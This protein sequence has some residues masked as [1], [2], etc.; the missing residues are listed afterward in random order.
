MRRAARAAVIPALF[1]LAPSVAGAEIGDY[2]GKPVSGVRLQAEGRTISDG[3]LLEL[4]ET[5]AGRPLSMAAVRESV[6]HLFSLGRFEDVRVHADATSSGVSLVYELV[7]MHP[8]SE[9]VFASTPAGVDG[10]ELRR[11][12]VDRFGASPPL[13]RSAEAADIV[14]E[15]LRQHGYLRPTVNPRAELEHDP[16]RATLVFVIDSGARTRLGTLDVKSDSAV[17]A[18]P[19]LARLGLKP[20]EAYEPEVLN[21]RIQD[22]IDD[23]RGRGYYGATVRLTTTLVDQD[24]TANLLFAVSHGPRVRIVFAGDAL[25]EDRRNELVPLAR[26]G[27]IDEDLLEDS[28]SRVEEYLRAQGY[29]TASAP[30]S[31]ELTGGEMVITF[32]V[33]RGP[34]YR[35][36][37]Y[38]ISGN[39][40]IPLAD[41]QRSLRI[42]EGQPFSDASLDADVAAIGDLYRRAGFASVKVDSGVDPQALAPDAP[43]VPVT[44]RII[45]AENARTIVGSVSVEGNESVSDAELVQALGLQP[46]RPFFLPQMAL[47]RDVLEIRYA[48]LGYRNASV[49]GNPGFSADGTRADV[50]FTV[51]EGPQLIVDHILI[52]GNARTGTETIERELQFKPGDALG[53]AR[54]T[55]SQ[56]RLAALGLFR[57]TRITELRHG[58]ETARDV[59]VTVDEAPVSTVGFG[60]GL[61]AGPRT[62][63]SAGGVADERLDLAP[64]AFFEIGRRNLFGKNRSINLFTRISVRR[65]IRPGVRFNE[66]RVLGTYREPRVLGTVADAFLTGTIEQQSRTSFNFA[67]RAFSAEAARPI[68]RAFSVSGNY[69]IQR[70]ELFDEVFDEEDKQ[71]I[72]RVFP[73]VVL[74]S[75]SLSAI[76]STRDDPV[77]PTSGHYF[78]A[79]GQIAGRAIGSEVGLAKTYLTGQWFATLPRTNEVVFAASARLGMAAGFPREVIRPD[80]AGA[81]ETGPGGQPVVDVVRD[82]P[83]SERFF[84]GGDTTVRGFALDQLG[85]PGKTLDENGFPIGGNALVILNAELRVPIAGGFGVVGFFDTGNVFERTRDVNFGELRSAIGF[86]LR[87]RSP[88]GP[89]RVDLGFKVNRRLITPDRLETPTALHISLGQAF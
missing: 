28:T 52:V 14:A 63:E 38:E 56:R 3:R 29:S 58:Q 8:V 42:R 69:Q 33:K 19:L 43:E 53:L 77:N 80:G 25:P 4:V 66:Y 64:R 20:G 13:R 39:T 47:D 48:D 6:T 75:F 86:G 18:A 37:R 87:Y 55:E 35:V 12:V 67:R 36:A 85:T 89:I 34:R 26:E 9:I 44:V 70:T 7:P 49:E 46:G 2:L 16:E 40:F 60:G 59:L 50:V 54:V 27:A 88:V 81:V 15:I 62:G 23:W 74:S 11:A 76:Q 71:L 5:M 22:Y 45:V 51:R 79:N 73:Q 61:E 57:R 65:R 41:F 82:L 32:D 1:L 10:D 21:G 84:A 68:T 72:D 30:Y 24:R 78:S 31:R 17:A 83:A